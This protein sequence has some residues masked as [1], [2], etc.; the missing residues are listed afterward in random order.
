MVHTDMYV[1]RMVK[2]LYA[3]LTYFTS[4][5]RLSHTYSDSSSQSVV[6]FKKP[7]SSSENWTLHYLRTHLYLSWAYTSKLFQHTTKTHVPLCSWQPFYNSQKLEI[8][9]CPSTEEWIKKIWY[10][11]TMEYYSAIKHNEFMKFLGKWIELENIILSEVTQAPHKKN[12][13]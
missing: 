4:V 1:L 9:R 8:P 2:P 10:I 6:A 5:S 3:C 12:P 13:E 11:Y 7:L